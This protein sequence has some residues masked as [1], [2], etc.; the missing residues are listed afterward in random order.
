M[1]FLKKN[2]H[3]KWHNSLNK[4][5]L[6][7]GIHISCLYLMKMFYLFEDFLII[8]LL[9]QFLSN[10]LLQRTCVLTNLVPFF[11]SWCHLEAKIIFSC[12]QPV[13]V[14]F[15]MIFA[16][17][18]FYLLLLLPCCCCCCYCVVSWHNML[19]PDRDFQA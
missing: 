8:A 7:C 12:C 17:C 2:I 10:D 14:Y 4:D 9:N 15:Y 3:I 13:Y 19:W 16:N 11:R 5:L 6:T 18:L 1:Y